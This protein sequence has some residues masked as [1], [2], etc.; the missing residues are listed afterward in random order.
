M[1]LHVD[2]PEGAEER[3][4]NVVRTAFAE[5]EP[6]PRQR[7]YLRPALALGI[8]AAVVAG[9]VSS[10]GRAVL[11]DLRDEVVGQ[12]NAA[13]ALF[14]LPAPGRLIAYSTEGPWIVQ[15]DGSKRRLD[16][17]DEL[18]W[19][20]HGKYVVATRNRELFALEPDGEIRWSLARRGHLSRPRWGG[21]ASDTRIAYLVGRN[22]RVVAGDGKGD[23]LIARNVALAAPAWRPARGRHLL[24]FADARGGIHL[25][26]VDRP[27]PLR[28][29]APG[30]I[31]TELRW[32]GDGSLL[33][34]LAPRSLRIL[35]QNRSLVRALRLPNG[36]HALAVEPATKR[37]ALTQRLGRRRSEL[38]LYES[39][40]P[41]QRP[42]ALF[43][44]T[45]D[46][47]GLEWSPD[48][49]W[50]LLAWPTADQWLFIRLPL[51]QNILPVARVGEQFSIRGVF[52]AL[53]SWCCE[54]R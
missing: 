11:G 43:A 5:R 23:R 37:F 9:A 16:R 22:L 30:E 21:T 13:P 2:I 20:P 18:S 29:A 51:G 28:R 53:G 14:S 41:G 10:P 49:R 50:L 8:A 34:V 7:S 26:D 32:S 45:G 33:F 6:V 46:F 12:R 17:Y 48:G 35:R 52:P 44:A 27:A 31:P 54:Q 19:S 4:W 38:L 1:N 42:R 15:R 47:T 40:R 39:I 24:A 36:P 25:V 3:A